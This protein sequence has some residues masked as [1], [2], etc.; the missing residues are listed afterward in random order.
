[1]R[2]HPII[3]LTP[4]AFCGIISVSSMPQCI[5][6]FQYRE[7]YAYALIVSNPNCFERC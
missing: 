3:G 5:M 6:G 1:M 4:G 7:G 2:G